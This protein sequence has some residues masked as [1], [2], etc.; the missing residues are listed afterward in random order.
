MTIPNNPFV[1][2][3]V[4]ILSPLRYPGSKRRL[5]GYI[6]ETLKL[7][8][9]RPKLLVE[10]FAGGL[11]AALQLLNDNLVDKIAVGE[12][13]PL[14]ASFWKSVFKEPDWLIEQIGTIPVTLEQWDY[15]KNNSFKTIR[16]RALAC[17]FLNRT[18]FS[19]ILAPGAG[20]I[21][22]RSQT[23]DYK[24]DCRFDVEMLT[25]RIRQAA[26]LR[27]R[28]L[29]VDQADWQETISKIE[30]LGYKQNE[31]FYYLD[32]PFFNKAENLYSY[33]FDD[34][35][36]TELHNA[37][38]KLR[39]PWLLSYD[40]ADS[41]I[42]MYSH[43]GYG[44][45]HIDILYSVGPSGNRLKTQEVVITNISTLPKETRIWRSK[46]EWRK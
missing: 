2:R 45:K 10:P 13:D 11:S 12:K 33:Y 25:K 9:L 40:K 38:M 7:N 44:P 24:I 21:G 20:P 39:Q 41:I 6:A 34:D 36:H 18:S 8:S 30:N 26:A 17:I 4:S 29:F 3:G 27:S 15:F 37:L 5:S 43:N 16:E 46:E 22:G 23:S 42:E 19:G 28:V 32:P 14:V 35:K 31:V 1:R